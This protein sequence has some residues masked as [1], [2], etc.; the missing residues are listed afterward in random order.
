MIATSMMFS[1]LKSL[2]AS[3][4]LHH[5]P[6]LNVRKEVLYNSSQ[7]PF[8]RSFESIQKKI[9]FRAW[10]ASNKRRENS[11]GFSTSV[12]FK[13]T[14]TF[15]TTSEWT[16]IK[17]TSRGEVALCR[18]VTRESAISATERKNLTQDY[19]GSS[20]NK[21]TRNRAMNATSQVCYRI[22]TNRSLLSIMKFVKNKYFWKRWKLLNDAVNAIE[23]CLMHVGEK[24]RRYFFKFVKLSAY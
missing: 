6:K 20:R 23:C 2:Y 22:K 18:E 16:V 13:T 5:G 11:E 24:V 9:F 8:F 14:P 17:T 15:Q 3:L 7:N 1:K 12:L 21:T 10:K 19:D 4:L